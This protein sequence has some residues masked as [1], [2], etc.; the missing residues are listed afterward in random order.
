MLIQWLRYNIT[1]SDD[2]VENS[3]AFAESFG[4]LAQDD[5][6]ARII[7]RYG[8]EQERGGQISDLETGSAFFDP[9]AESVS[10][11]FIVGSESAKNDL[12]SKPRLQQ[13]Y[14]I[15]PQFMV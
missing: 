10:S 6:K 2:N 1:N 14:G 4:C 11:D 3:R 5:R 9:T 8:G 12:I 15:Q 7:S 13:L